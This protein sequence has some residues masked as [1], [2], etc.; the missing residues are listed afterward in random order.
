MPSSITYRVND[1]SDELY[2]TWTEPI[3]IE[4]NALNRPPKI[5]YLKATAGEE[6]NNFRFEARFFDEDGS[7]DEYEFR[8]NRDPELDSKKIYTKGYNY[9]FNKIFNSSYGERIIT[10]RVK[11]ND[12]AWTE[13]ETVINVDEPFIKKA[14]VFFF[15]STIVIFFLSSM[16]VMIQLIL[17]RKKIIE[18]I[19]RRKFI[20]S[21]TRIWYRYALRR[22]ILGKNYWNHQKATREW[23]NQ[24]TYLLEITIV[25]SV[26]LYVLS[27]AINLYNIFKD[28]LY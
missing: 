7:I 16:L 22:I 20:K 8:S 10:L 1:G 27:K 18:W 23:L 6:S 9:S 2:S 14:Y 4:I 28:I 17:N 13:K 25:I 11:D 21:I 12:G 19:Q 5:E 24:L 3:F 26:T 15:N